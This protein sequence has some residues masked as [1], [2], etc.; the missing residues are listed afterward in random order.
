MKKLYRTLLFAPGTR[1]EL[2]A[3]AQAGAA[4]A[5]IFDLE[6]SVPPTP[7]KTRAGISPRPSTRA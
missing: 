1:P 5:M 4:D 3:K 7:R 2:L 6:D